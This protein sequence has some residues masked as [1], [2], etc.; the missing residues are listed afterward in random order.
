M[1]IGVNLNS[2]EGLIDNNG[3]SR[4]RGIN[5]RLITTPIVDK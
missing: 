5:E 2:A 4:D 3:Q 1:V